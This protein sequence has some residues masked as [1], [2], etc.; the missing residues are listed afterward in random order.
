MK[1]NKSKFLDYL[2]MRLKKF[3]Q[4]DVNDV[5]SYYDEYISDAVKDGKTE[6]QVIEELGS[7][8]NII[9]NITYD[10][11]GKNKGNN[12]LPIVLITIGLCASPLL[13]PVALGIIIVLITIGAVWISLIGAFGAAALGCLAV[14]VGCFIFNNFSFMNNLFILGAGLIGFVLF[15]V[16]TY[17][18]VKHGWKLIVYIISKISLFVKKII[19]RKENKE[20]EIN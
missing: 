1:M 20:N 18:L 5:I 4:E 8:N 3:K 12:T 14:G 15:Y 9:A 16:L 2:R 13:L 19:A 10:L 7:K 11:A 6:E 17:V